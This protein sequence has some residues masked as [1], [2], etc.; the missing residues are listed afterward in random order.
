[1]SRFKALTQITLIQVSLCATVVTLGLF[2]GLIPDHR[3]AQMEGRVRLCE[4]LALNGAVLIGQND[5]HR[6]QVILEE[7]VARHDD[8]LSAGIR[9]KDGKLVISIGPH[10]QLWRPPADGFS[11]NQFM[12]IPIERNQKTWGNMELHFTPIMADSVL[13]AFV[14]H[15]WTRFSLYCS[16]ACLPVFWLSLRRVL[17]QFDP[18]KAV[19]KHVRSAYDFLAG[20][21]VALN[22][23]RRIVL[24]NAAF[25][26]TIGVPREQLI[27]KGLDVLPWSHITEDCSQPFPWENVSKDAPSTES[28]S[29]R[30]TSPHGQRTLM[31]NAA[32]VLNQDGVSVG[33]LV[34][35]EDIT[36]L[37]Q[38]KAELEKSKQAAEAA[39]EAKSA[40]LA[41]MSHEI[42]TPMNA[43]LGFADIMRRWPGSNPRGTL[44]IPQHHS[45]QRRAP[46][47]A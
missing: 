41:N 18:S 36:P 27:G 10:E 16:A 15:P 7:L 5:L 1:M 26:E 28:A 42:R 33:T 40:F 47:S 17:R 9:R 24:C 4:S 35:F 20:G 31:V 6:W 32:P 25:V 19:P 46:V 45:L 11:S 23:Q 39:N 38:T 2:L 12:T 13:L 29:L 44:R 43:I 3:K 8:F 21:L 30:I 14:T 22:T 34:G 37:E